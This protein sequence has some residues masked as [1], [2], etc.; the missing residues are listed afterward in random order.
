MD[1]GVEQTKIPTYLA[2]HICNPS[3][4]VAEAEGCELETSLSSRART[5]KTKTWKCGSVGRELAWH[6]CVSAPGHSRTK[7]IEKSLSLWIFYS[8]TLGDVK[9]VFVYAMRHGSFLCWYLLFLVYLQ[10]SELSEF[11]KL[12]Y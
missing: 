11:T 4:E 7:S 6:I 10:E 5:E 3:S 8:R 1:Q 2:Y 9:S 12:L